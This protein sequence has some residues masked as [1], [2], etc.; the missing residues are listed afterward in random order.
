MTHQNLEFEKLLA[1]T[2]IIPVMVI[3]DVKDAVPMARDLMGQGFRVL[4]ITLR[5][6]CALA[7]ITEIIAEIPDAIVGVGTVTNGVQLRAAYEAG[8]KFAVS[9]GFTDALLKAAEDM[10]IPLLPGVSTASEAMTLQ[11]A[12]YRYLKLFP[13]EAVGGCALLK[14]LYGPLPNL[15]FCPTGGITAQSAKDYL[16]LPNVISVGGSWMMSQR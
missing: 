6:D 2:T 3:K 7:A 10:P 9:P 11:D 4:E 14:A 15:F 8:A 1:G 13:A 12:G 16:S 5:T